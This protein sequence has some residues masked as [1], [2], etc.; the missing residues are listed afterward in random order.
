MSTQCAFSVL[1]IRPESRHCLTVS[2]QELTDSLMLLRSINVT[3]AVDCLI[4]MPPTVPYFDLP[5]P[6]L[7]TR[8]NFYGSKWL[9]Q[10]SRI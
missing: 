2:T 3:L 9:V 5:W 4:L 10:V 1:F 6:L 8:S 7:P